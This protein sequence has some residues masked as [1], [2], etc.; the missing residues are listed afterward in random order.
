[1]S[2][3]FG[4]DDN[5][6]TEQDNRSKEQQTLVN[7]SLEVTM[8]HTEPKL[9]EDQDT[10]PA[11]TSE[12]AQIQDIA[13]RIKDVPLSDQQQNVVS[14]VVVPKR[15]KLKVGIRQRAEKTQIQS[16]YRDAEK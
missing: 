10:L 2:S 5:L 1:M 6:V 15:H 7:T 9:D 13:S 4:L 12:F 8:K 11:N 16:A 3:N 14:K